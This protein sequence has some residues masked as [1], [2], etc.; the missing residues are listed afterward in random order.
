[1]SD[2][3]THSA[4]LQAQPTLM[5]TLVPTVVP[6]MLPTVTPVAFIDYDYS[7]ASGLTPFSYF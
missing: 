4:V 6:T 5:T 2:K 1:M 7:A 3:L